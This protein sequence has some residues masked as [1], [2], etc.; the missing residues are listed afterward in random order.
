MSLSSQVLHIL[1]I[2]AAL[3]GVAQWIERGPANQRVT[4]F[5]PSQGTCLGCGPGPQLGGGAHERQPH[6]DVSLPS[7]P[8]SL[9][10]N[11]IKNIYIY[12]Y[13]YIYIYTYICVYIYIYTYICI[14]IGF[15]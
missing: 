7:S 3:A 12:I 4:G 13:V 10:K 11:K 6:I 8:S 9:S 5:I 15:F 1:K 2:L 14:Y